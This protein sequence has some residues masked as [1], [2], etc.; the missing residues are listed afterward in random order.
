[1]II[2]EYLTDS[3]I[4]LKYF[5]LLFLQLRLLKI[6]CKLVVIQWSYERNKK[7]AFLLIHCVD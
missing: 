1:M 6:L 3:E 2:K 5:K 7:G 4:L